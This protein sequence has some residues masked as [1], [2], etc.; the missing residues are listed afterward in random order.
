MSLSEKLKSLKTGLA[1][2]AAG[3]MITSVAYAKEI[4]NE[5]WPIPDEKGYTSFGESRTE[6]VECDYQDKKITVKIKAESYINNPFNKVKAF[7]KYS[8]EDKTF[9]YVI[10][11]AKG[12]TDALDMTVLADRDGNG[13]LETK[14]VNQEIE[15][16]LEEEGVIPQWIIDKTVQ[17]LKNS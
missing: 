5:G 6:Y 11:E 8:F 1:V 13:T 15:D 16:E 2:L 9:M 3:A 17:D 4:K 14:Y 12:N 10:I 7:M